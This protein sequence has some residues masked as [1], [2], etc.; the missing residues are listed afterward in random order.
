M[1]ME[2][3]DIDGVLSLLYMLCETNKPVRA[4]DIIFDVSDKLCADGKFEVWDALIRHVDVRRLST[5]A[6]RSL[7]V[8]SEWGRG[9][10]TGR[11]ELY[12]RVQ[13][14]MTAVSGEEKTRK[15]IGVFA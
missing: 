4:T 15:V 8:A 10:L 2:E 14:A 3:S 11:E 1:N 6:M 7:L 5:S 12:L 9:R 13:A